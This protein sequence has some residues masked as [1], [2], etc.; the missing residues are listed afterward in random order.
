MLLNVP[1]WTAL[2]SSYLRACYALS[3]FPYAT[4]ATLCRHFSTLLKF[5]SCLP[6]T[7][8]GTRFSAAI[9]FRCSSN[10]FFQPGVLKHVS[11]SVTMGRGLAAVARTSMSFVIG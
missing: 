7:L 6:F 1:G 4:V 3:P 10:F 2:F 9:L 8:G 11:P 5:S